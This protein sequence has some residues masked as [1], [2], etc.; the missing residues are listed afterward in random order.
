MPGFSLSLAFRLIDVNND[1]YI[2]GNSL[3][4]YLAH[5]GVIW[6]YDDAKSLVNEY[7]YEPKDGKLT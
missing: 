6:T 7:D 2:T 3:Q 5:I 1:G 4:K